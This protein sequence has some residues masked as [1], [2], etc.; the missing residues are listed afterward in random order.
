[1]NS[2]DR[3][4]KPDTK[5]LTF[6]NDTGILKGSL[7]IAKGSSISTNKQVHEMPEKP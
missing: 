3:I 2:S 6:M 4:K 1:M 5:E 7:N